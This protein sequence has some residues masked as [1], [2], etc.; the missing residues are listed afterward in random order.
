VNRLQKITVHVPEDLLANACRV[1]GA[2]VT[3][4]VREG[5]RTLAAAKAAEDLRKLRGRLKLKIDVAKLRRDR[6]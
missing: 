6:R 1:T 2:G 3:E 4:T 5:L